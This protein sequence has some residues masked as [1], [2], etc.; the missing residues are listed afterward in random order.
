MKKHINAAILVLALSA[1]APENSTA[2]GFLTFEPDPG[3]QWV[4]PDS[5]WLET[6]W[7]PG[8]Q[9]PENNLVRASSAEG[10]W[11]PSPGY[12]WVYNPGDAITSEIRKDI[13]D[14]IWESGLRHP[15][16]EHISSD[17]VE[18]Q[19]VADPG[20]VFRESGKLQT[21]WQEGR[22]H[23]DRVHFVSSPIEGEWLPEAGYVA[24]PVF[25]LFGEKRDPFA[26]WSPGTV[27]PKEECMIAAASEGRWQP[28]DGYHLERD[29]SDGLRVVGDE[30]Q[31]DWGGVFA[32]L[33]VA[34]LGYSA[35]QPT[36]EDGLITSQVV[37]PMAAEVA[38]EGLKS[39]GNAVGHRNSGSC[40]GRI[41]NKELWGQ[42]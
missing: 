15:E 30:V 42:N 32:G 6:E 1:C 31:T 3:Y 7:A 18:R 33:V 16:Y 40:D 5:F 19:W 13:S 26:K 29:G 25:G 8:L 17:E 34:Y 35:S 2:K 9:H 41:L 36:S 4:D 27:H 20:Y 37:R 14:V 24:V 39:A 23:P 38:K 11:Q 12:V 22:R 21:V 10:Y 28:V